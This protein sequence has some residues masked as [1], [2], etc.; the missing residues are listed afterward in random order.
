MI[1]TRDLY[2]LANAKSQR[3]RSCETCV[4]ALLVYNIG[5]EIVR[6][7]CDRKRSQAYILRWYTDQEFSN[8]S[9]GG[10]VHPGNLNKIRN[11][12]RTLPRLF[13]AFSCF[14]RQLL[15]I[16]IKAVVFNGF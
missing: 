1:Y 4:M 16:F 11:I 14:R 2:D 3:N 8:Q 12:L 6:G 5:D 10:L 13:Y 15:F 9:L 7:R